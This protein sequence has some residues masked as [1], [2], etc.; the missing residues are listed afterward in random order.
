[1]YLR[2]KKVFIIL[3][4]ININ[5]LFSISTYNRDIILQARKF[6]T[7]TPPLPKDDFLRRITPLFN[8]LHQLR[9]E[10][11]LPWIK[12]FPTYL[13]KH[14]SYSIY[15]S[16]RPELYQLWQ[17][18]IL[19]TTDIFFNIL[20][21]HQFTAASNWLPI[22]HIYTLKIQALSN[23]F[24]FCN[25]FYSHKNDLFKEAL[26]AFELHFKAKFISFP[27]AQFHQIYQFLESKHTLFISKHRPHTALDANTYDNQVIS[28][29][30]L[31]E[32]FF[33]DGNFKYPFLSFLYPLSILVAIHEI[34]S[35]LEAN[36]SLID[37]IKPLN[38][39][40][41]SVTHLLIDILSKRQINDDSS[42]DLGIIALEETPPQSLDYAVILV[43]AAEELN[44]MEGSDIIKIFKEK[45]LDLLFQE[46]EARLALQRRPPLLESQQS[47]SPQSKRKWLRWLF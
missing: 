29:T 1:M 26:Q 27:T 31:A 25:Q 21:T 36:P 20:I 6:L 38:I 24:Q 23:L 40:S 17:H 8:L 4:A 41:T 13:Q 30:T 32:N 15:H 7:Q 18:E 12:E 43:P 3:V 19:Q 22:C 42:E 33:V 35:I 47:P 45:P 9:K 28:N 10:S 16:Q 37:L 2:Y 34:D 46:F 11:H 5:N 14:L 44:P 39:F